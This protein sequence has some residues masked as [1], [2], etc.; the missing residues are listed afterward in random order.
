MTEILR[1][2]TDVVRLVSVRQS[3]S[4]M[5]MVMAMVMVRCKLDVVHLVQ[6]GM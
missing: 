5:K 6:T 4:T 3:G 1:V 2:E